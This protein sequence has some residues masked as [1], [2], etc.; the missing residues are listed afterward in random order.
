MSEQ[1]KIRAVRDFTVF[2]D[3]QQHDIKKGWQHVDKEVADH[4]MTKG[5][6]DNSDDATPDMRDA[7]IVELA[8][9]NSMLTEKLANAERTAQNAAVTEGKLA[10]L[11]T[12]L[13]MVT[14]DRDNAL[15]DKNIAES[16]VGTLQTELDAVRA[17]LV[18]AQATTDNTTAKRGK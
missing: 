11:E 7:Q 6:T 5:F 14:A 10:E 4:F 8:G 1:V 12:A 18:A 3:G 15:A 2:V 16:K 13:H 9:Q 17:E